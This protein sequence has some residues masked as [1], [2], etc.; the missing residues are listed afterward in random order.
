MPEQDRRNVLHKRQKSAGASA[1][2]PFHLPP[3]LLAV[4]LAPMKTRPPSPLFLPALA[5]LAACAMPGPAL[6]ADNPPATARSLPLIVQNPDDTMTAQRA[7][8]KPGP[9]S[10]KAGKGFRVPAQVIVPLIPARRVDRGGDK[11]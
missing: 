6:C 3:G 11:K 1:P 2:A 9:N 8:P 5:V 4:V 7:L 10:T